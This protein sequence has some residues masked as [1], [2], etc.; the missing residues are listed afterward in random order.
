V[1]NKSKHFR[2]IILQTHLPNNITILEK[3][4]IFRPEIATSQKKPA[5]FFQRFSVDDCQKEWDNIPN[6]SWSN[7]NSDVVMF[8]SEVYNDKDSA[9]NPRFKNIANLAIALLTLPIS[10]ATVER[11]FSVYNVIKN[12]IRNMLSLEM[13]ET[14]VWK[15]SLDAVKNTDNSRN[16]IQRERW[17]LDICRSWIEDRPHD[18]THYQP[19][20]VGGC[21]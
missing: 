7:V 5:A 15:K 3:I 13:V 20:S 16:V 6:K 10:N 19:S 17:M 1:Q 12:K 4:N 2:I 18:A 11:A 14:N 9:D 8:W 21:S